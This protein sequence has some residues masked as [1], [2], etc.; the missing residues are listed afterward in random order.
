MKI[1]SQDSY[2]NVVQDVQYNP[3]DGQPYIEARLSAGSMLISM[4]SDIEYLRNELREIK[5]AC[6]IEAET[7]ANHPAVKDLYDQYKSMLVLIE[8]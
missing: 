8:T 3:S 4:Q 7:L 5:H 2:I 1:I 6:A